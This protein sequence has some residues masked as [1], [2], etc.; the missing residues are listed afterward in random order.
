[1][2]RATRLEVLNDSDA[3]CPCGAALPDDLA[4]NEAWFVDV[5]A[6]EAIVRCPECW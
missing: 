3:Q 1:M 5:V 2:D 4:E 6:G